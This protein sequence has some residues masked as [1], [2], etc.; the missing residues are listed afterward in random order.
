MSEDV[1]LWHLLDQTNKLGEIQSDMRQVKTRLEEG[2]RDLK[3][4]KTELKKKATKDDV[5][6]M[7]AAGVTKHETDMHPSEAEV[8]GQKVLTRRKRIRKWV[9]GHPKEDA[10][11]GL[12]GLVLA[13][14]GFDKGGL[15]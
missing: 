11:I 7:V 12:V 5:G 10:I 1:I 9:E 15:L 4:I 8:L 2:D 14:L 3:E 6:N 13:L